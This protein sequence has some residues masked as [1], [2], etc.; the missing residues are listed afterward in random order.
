MTHHS[1]ISYSV[2]SGRE[3][4]NAPNKGAMIVFP[5][6][7]RLVCVFF[8][9]RDLAG[10]VFSIKHRNHVMSALTI[11][12]N[13]SMRSFYFDFVR[14]LVLGRRRCS[15][16]VRWCEQMDAKCERSPTR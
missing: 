9:R 2:C 12:L 8:F 15:F 3:E 5:F 14:F 6:G 16:V 1:H 4:E 7:V 11:G 13:N 10:T